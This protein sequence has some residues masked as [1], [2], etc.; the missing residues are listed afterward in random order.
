M[1]HDFNRS[2]GWIDEGIYYEGSGTSATVSESW[3]NDDTG[4][5]V[6]IDP[7]GSDG[8]LVLEMR[9]RSSSESRFP[10]SANRLI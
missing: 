6:L 8:Y 1:D 2:F 7:E 5:V 10:S 3:I 4:A 9:E